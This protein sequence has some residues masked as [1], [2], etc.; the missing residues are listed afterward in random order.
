MVLQKGQTENPNIWATSAR[1][2]MSTCTTYTTLNKY[3]P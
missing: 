1:N 3:W 2:S